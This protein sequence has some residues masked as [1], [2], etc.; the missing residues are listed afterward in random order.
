MARMATEGSSGLRREVREF[1][2]EQVAG[3]AVLNCDS[4]LTGFSPAFSRAQG[5][6]G[7]LGMTWP[8]KY[9]GHG[10]SQLD[11]F[12]VNEEL[13]A[14]GAP[15]AA[16]WIADRQSGPAILSHGT[17]EQRARFLPLIAGGTS[18]FSIGMSE[19]NS[20]SDLASITSRAVRVDGGWRV[21]GT[22]VWTSHA[23]QSH[24]MIALFRTSPKQE[25]A[26]HAGLTQFIVDLSVPGVQINPIRNMQGDHHF[27]EVVLDDV[28]LPDAS[29]L[30]VEGQGWGQV[31]AELANERS[32]AERFLST[33]PLLS[34]LSKRLRGLP[35]EQE[36][37]R[38][39][40][41]L[42][43][44]RAMSREVASAL[45]R[46]E[47]PAVKAVL[48]KD[49]GTRFESSVIDVARRLVPGRP[50]VRSED[51][52]ERLLGQAILSAPG[53]TL[54]GGTNEILRGIVAK[55]VTTA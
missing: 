41:D 23:H 5:Q 26:R 45:E 6:R 34:E 36:L 37:G 2:R 16:H 47:N 29:L 10:R 22:K 42:L 20:G 4:W 44:L 51:D 38:V 1:V 3:G 17:E 7:W 14:A 49:L 19:P 28:F 39:L 8:K 48:V 21:Q 32:G 12:V 46:G 54:R 33:M 24:F 9:G 13:L 30:G 27:N 18:F 25:M 53:F 40:A 31:T 11:R 35:P 52:Y 15:V 55:A 50:D 43:T